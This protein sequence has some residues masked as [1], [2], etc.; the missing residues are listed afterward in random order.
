V[1]RGA[2]T[3]RKARAAGRSR[4]LEH[5]PGAVPACPR[6]G[7]R[8]RGGAPDGPARRRALPRLA[9]TLEVAI[10][11]TIHVYITP[12]NDSFHT[13]QPGRPPEWADATAWPELGAIFLRAPDLR[14]GGDEPLEQVLDHELAHVLLGRAFAPEHPPIWLQEGVA[15]VL[16]RQVGPETG[17][18]LAEGAA[19]GLIGPLEGI[20]HGFPV[21]PR[22]AQ[23][24]YAQSADFVAFLMDIGGPDTLPTL[25]STSAG[26][27][28][29]SAAVYKATGHFL[30]DVEI[31]W[32]A[33]HGRQAFGIAAFADVS[34]LWGLGA[35]VLVG[36]GIAR[37]R[38]FRRRLADMEREEALY[39]AWLAELAAR[40]AAEAGLIGYLGPSEAGWAGAGSD[41]SATRG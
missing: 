9:D 8:D 23:L 7:I 39:D 10:G 3:R 17:R 12:T 34:W 41:G 2:R 11:S 27:A 24:A 32:R 25:V 18:T 4:R 26:G 16:A 21:D 6:A 15:Q 13:L 35:F 30:E 5:H 22:K 14:V 1:D 31:D 36:A 20:E 40:R 29:M 38:R 28:P 19:S 37:R 33:R